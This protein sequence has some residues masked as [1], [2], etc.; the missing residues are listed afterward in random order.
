MNN[1]PEKLEF[2]PQGGSS[3]QSCSIEWY[4]EGQSRI[5]ECNGLRITI[6][7]VG[8]KGRRARIAIAA[9]AGATFSSATE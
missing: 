6:R 5:V 1:F 7:L 9:P 4:A 2:M 3:P 8:R